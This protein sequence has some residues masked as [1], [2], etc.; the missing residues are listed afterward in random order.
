M[1]ESSSS[2]KARVR[3]RLTELKEGSIAEPKSN[4]RTKIRLD[5]LDS[6]LLTNVH[7]AADW[8]A[9]LLEDLQG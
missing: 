6:E 1:A 3:S 8:I 7:G 5:K 9:E 4:C 2:S